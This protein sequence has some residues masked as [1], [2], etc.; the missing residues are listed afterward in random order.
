MRTQLQ[1]LAKLKLNGGRE[2]LEEILEEIKDKL[3]PDYVIVRTSPFIPHEDDGDC[4][5][6]VTILG[7]RYQ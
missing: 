5:I 2:T 4:H 6:Y 7:E 1:E 3:A